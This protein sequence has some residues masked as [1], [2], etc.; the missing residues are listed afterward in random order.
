[1]VHTRLHC[2]KDF[3]AELR[4]NN[5]GVEALVSPSFPYFYTFYKLEDYSDPF[6]CWFSIILH[7]KLEP[8]VL[9]LKDQMR[10]YLQFPAVL[11]NL[12]PRIPSS[13]NLTGIHQWGISLLL[14]GNS[15]VTQ[16]DLTLLF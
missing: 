6:L 13:L 14:S 11:C 5:N 9:F 1:M 15:F 2:S 3:D 10:Q 8:T 12:N 7:Q 4:N 16:S